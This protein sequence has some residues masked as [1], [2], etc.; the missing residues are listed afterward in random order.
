M[1]KILSYNV[2]KENSQHRQDRVWSHLYELCT[3]VNPDIICLQE[4]LIKKEAKNGLAQFVSDKWPYQVMAAYSISGHRDTYANV[5]LSKVP[6]LSNSPLD[7]S[8]HGNVYSEIQVKD[9]RIHLFCTHFS[10]TANKRLKDYKSLVQA[11][12]TRTK[13]NSMIVVAGD[14]NDVNLEIH[15]KLKTEMALQEVFESTKGILVPT[16]PSLLPVLAV[17]RIYYKGLQP[18][19]AIRILDKKFRFLSDHLALVSELNSA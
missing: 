11:I 17:D 3:Q 15:K 18:V 9:N 10:T 7:I 12:K 13:S 6:F 14:F 5:I 2:H 19:N 8:T 4:C 1:I 16:C